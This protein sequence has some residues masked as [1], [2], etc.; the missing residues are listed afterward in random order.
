[1]V[2]SRSYR[3]KNKQD[4][5]AIFDQPFKVTHRYFQALFRLNERSHARLGLMIAKHRVPRAVDRNKI[6]RIIRESFREHAPL[7][8]GLDIIVLLRQALSRD[9]TK[10]QLRVD[11]EHLWQRILKHPVR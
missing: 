10:A 11:V 9:V 8:K 2:F 1:M 7:L 6:R 3:L 5:Q 4:F